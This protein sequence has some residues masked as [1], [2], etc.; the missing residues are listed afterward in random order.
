MGNTIA[1]HE[2]LDHSLSTIYISAYYKNILRE[3]L[4]GQFNFKYRSDTD[5][6]DIPLENECQAQ[7]LIRYFLMLHGIPE[8]KNVKWIDSFSKEDMPETGYGLYFKDR[9]KKLH[10]L[11]KSGEK[12]VSF[13]GIEMWYEEGL[14]VVLQ[15]DSPEF[16]IL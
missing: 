13:Q 7:E 12:R 10:L 11:W 9:D 3:K 2:L 8:A 5:N 16:T 6:Y 4:E 1:K 14:G 15:E